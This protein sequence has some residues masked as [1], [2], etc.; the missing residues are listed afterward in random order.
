M[1]LVNTNPEASNFTCTNHVNSQFD[2]NMTRINDGLKEDDFSNMSLYNLMSKL[3][4]MKLEKDRT[5][6][7]IEAENYTITLEPNADNQN[8]SL[9]ELRRVVISQQYRIQNNLKYLQY[10]H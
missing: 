7:N 1:T 6:N 9:I 2:H 10:L 3:K 5:L 8:F 4:S